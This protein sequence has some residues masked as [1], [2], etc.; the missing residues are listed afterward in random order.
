VSPED[1]ADAVA[2]IWVDADACPVPIKEIVYRAAERVGIEAVF[3][4]N[5]DLRVPRSPLL[6]TVRV[7][8]GFDVAD[9]YIAERVVPGDVVVTADVPLAAQVVARGAT[10]LDPRG[11]TI[12]EDNVG[13]RLAT[14][15][16]LER[17]RETGMVG[18]GPP[19]LG[20]SDRQAFASALDRLLAR[21]TR[22]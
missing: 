14:R 22:A 2:R 7:S 8:G 9:R 1:R 4:A 6:R 5:R 17:L 19:P 12:T 21:R 18:G 15:D 3:V 11:D 10:A 20:K 16:L 13:E